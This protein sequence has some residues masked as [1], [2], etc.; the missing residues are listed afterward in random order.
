[1]NWAQRRLAA[2]RAGAVE[3]QN[4]K[5]TVAAGQDRRGDRPG[6]FGDGTAQI[7][8]RAAASRACS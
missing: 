2:Q 6:A 7:R 5:G 8:A 4:F 3:H 1:M